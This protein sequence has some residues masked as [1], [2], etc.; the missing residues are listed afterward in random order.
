MV[1]GFYMSVSRFLENFDVEIEAEGP[2]ADQL[3][4]LLPRG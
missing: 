1:I 4:G 3:P 2:P